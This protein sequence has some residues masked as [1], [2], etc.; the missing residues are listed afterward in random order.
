MLCASESVPSV[1]GVLQ[2]RDSSLP[3]Q[4]AQVGSAIPKPE[5]HLCS[6]TGAWEE[7]SA[8]FQHDRPV[9]CH[10]NECAGFLSDEPSAVCACGLGTCLAA[11]K[12][13]LTALRSQTHRPRHLVVSAQLLVQESPRGTTQMF[14]G[15]TAGE[16]G[17]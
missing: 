8:L 9:V 4:T 1:G 6:R 7:T 16:T 14:K 11:E 3:S 10:R 2:L 13:G 5:N 12:L 15:R 17:R